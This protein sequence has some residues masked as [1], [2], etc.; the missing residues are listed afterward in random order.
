MTDIT[1]M[2]IQQATRDLE[3]QGIN[4]DPTKTFIS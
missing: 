2:M 4:R 1:A 3:Q